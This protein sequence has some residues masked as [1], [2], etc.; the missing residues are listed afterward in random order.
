MDFIETVYL[1]M[2]APERQSVYSYLGAATKAALP[3]I[4]EIDVTDLTVTPDS[5]E[6]GE[7]VTV[8]F[9]ATNAGD[10]VAVQIFTLRIN[11]VTKI[12]EKVTLDAGESVT[13]VWSIQES[14]AG[15]YTVSVNGESA[16]LTIVAP[17]FQTSNLQVSPS[18]VT[19]GETVTITVDVENSGDA[20]GSYTVILTVNGVEVDEETVTVAAGGTETISFSLSEDV[21]DTYE[22]EV[23]GLTSSF[24]VAPP[25]LQWGPVVI[26]VIVVIV[27]TY[28]Y[29]QRRETE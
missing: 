2:S 9:V 27:A 6:R 4:G 20:S 19:P 13:V 11:S 18:P 15:A 21:E 28:L 3:E 8:S 5:A 26:A 29:M 12:T 25:G 7:D 17:E 1:G 23:D 22:V 24:T 16:S 14:T 10:E